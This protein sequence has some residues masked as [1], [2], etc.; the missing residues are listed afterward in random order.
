MRPPSLDETFAIL[1][2]R[3]F[4]PEDR[5]FKVGANLLSAR[6]ATIYATLTSHPDTHVMLGLGWHT[7][8]GSGALPPVY[9]FTFDPRSLH[10]DGWMYP[11]T[12]SDD[13][14]TPDVFFISGFQVDQRGNVNLFGI[15]GD[16]GAWKVRGPGGVGLASA[17]TYAGGYYIVMPR[18]DPRTF[19][20]RVNMVTALGDRIER[21]RLRLPGGGP[22]LVLSPLGCFDFDD[23]GD[24]RIQSLH[25]G[26]SLVQAQAAT[27]FP[28]VVPQ[29]I[30]ETVPPRDDEL[31]FL[32]TRVDVDGALSGR[33]AVR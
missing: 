12:G 10:A 14:H 26:V 24:M 28:L 22:R 23:A 33:M 16:D 13:M 4:R 1:L 5:T 19:V 27:G 2:A 25:A 17:T 21:R 31:E 8:D 29:E 6:A 9:P 18:H 30:R 15:R 3:D 20:G 7:F 32:R 11:W